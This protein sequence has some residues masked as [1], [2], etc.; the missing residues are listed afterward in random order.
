[1]KQLALFGISVL[2][3]STSLRADTAMVF[4][5][6][7]Y[8]P[9]VNEPALEWLEFHNQLAVD[10]DVSGW[11]V[12]GGISYTFP[13]GS[14]IR[15]RGYLV[16][17]VN[18]GA[19]ASATGL[20]N[21][22]GPFAGRLDNS[23]DT[24]ELRNNSGRLMDRLSYEADGNWPVGP[25]GAGVSLAKRDRNTASD[26]AANWTVSAEQ[27]GTPGVDNFPLIG[28]ALPDIPLVTFE[29]EWKYN[30]SGQDLGTAW[31]GTNYDDS[32]WS[33]GRAWFY[34]GSIGIS[35]R[36]PITTVYNTGIGTDGVALAP[37]TRDPHYVLTVAAQGTVP[38]N[39]LVTENHSAWLANDNSSR[40]VSVVTPGTANINGGA[41]FYSTTFDINGFNPGTAQLDINMAI[42]NL[43]TNVFLNGNP[44]AI[45]FVGF[46]ALSPTFTISSG[47]VD[48]L[49]TLEFRTVNEGVGPGAFRAEVRGSGLVTSTNTSL[50]AIAKYYLRKSFTYSGDGNVAL[51]LNSLIDD[52]AI[53]YLN[54]TEI[55]R[56]NMA[57]PTNVIQPAFSGQIDVPASSLA[58]GNNVLAV[59]L[60]QAP[61]DTSDILFD[62]ELVA[63]PSTT[64]RQTITFNE[65]SAGGADFWVEL[66]NGTGREV[67][68]E[69]L[70]LVRDGVSDNVYFFGEGTL[71]VDGFLVLS[72]ATLDFSVVSGDKLFLFEGDQLLDGIAIRNRARARFPNSNGHWFNP[73]TLTPGASNN[74]VFRS[75]I[76]INEIMYNHQPLPPTNNAVGRSSDE[77][78]IELYNRSSS[79]IDLTDWE[80]TG[81]I[82][83]RFTPGKTIPAH[84]YLVV[85]DDVAAL[86]AIYPAADIVG[87]YG[88]RLG[89]NGERVVLRDPS[90]NPADEVRYFEGGRWPDHTGGGGSSLELRNPDADNSNA[91]A[92]AASDESS[93]STWQT[94]NYAMT[95]AIPAASGQPT[96][97]NDF[98]M[99]LQSAGECLIDDLTVVE[100]NTGLA[101]IDNGDFENG[102]TGWRVLGTHNRSSVIV[103]PENPGNH[104]MRVV[105]TGPQE[106]MH[107]HIERTYLAGRS[108]QNNNGYRITFRAR[109]LAGNNLLNTR[110]YFNRVGRTAAL[111]TPQLNGTP[112]AQNSQYAANVGPTFTDFRHQPVIP[113]PSTPVRVS[114]KAADANG[115]TVARLW[116]SVNDT[117]WNNVVMDRNGSE[118]SGTI[119]GQSSGTIQFYVNATDSLGATTMFPA[120]GPDGGALYQVADGR[121]NL[122]L[123]HNV[124]II[125]TASNINYMHGVAQGSNQTNVMSNDL[126]PCTVIYDE[127]RAYYD[128]GV[129]LRGSQRGRY[130][131]VRT[132]FHLTFQPDDPFLGLHPVM[133]VDRSGAGDAAANR[134]ED[135]ILK[136]MLNRAG[137]LPGTYSQIAH[138]IAPRTA[139]SGAAQWFPRHEDNFIETA[140]ENG[141]DGTM[142]E[143]ELIY[144]PTT[145]NSIGYKLPQPDGV[146]G[147]DMTDMGNDKEFYR[148]NFMMKSHRNT[149]DYSRFIAICKAL[150]LTGT[151]LDTATRQ[152]MDIDQWMRAY[153][154][155]SLCSVGDMYTFGNNHNFFMYQRAGDGKF[156]YFPWDMDFT[157]TRGSSGALV[158]DQNLGKLVNLPGNLRCMYAH[159]LDIINTTFNTA[160]MGYWI[161]H[162]DNFA[163]GQNYSGH[164]TTLGARVTFVQSQIATAGGNSPFVVTGTNDITTST[165]LMTFTGTAPVTMKTIMI[166]GKEYP[167]TWTSVFN[168]RIVVPITE[169]SNRLDFVGYDIKGNPQTNLTRTVTVRYTGPLPNLDRA[170]VF[171]EIMY[172][173]QTPDTAF[174]ELYNRSGAALDISDWR[175]NGL[176]Y[177]FPKGSIITNG[178]YLL[179]VNQLSAYAAAFGVNATV[180]FDEFNASLQNDGETLTLLRP[181]ITAGQE[182]VV[183]RVKYEDV[184]P[185]PAAADGQ[186]A[187]LQLIDANENNARVGNWADPTGWRYVTYTGTIQG[188]ATPS[189]RG[190][191]FFM[192]LNSAGDV[193]IDDMKLVIGTVPEAG[194]NLLVNGDFEDAL[195]P[196]NWNISGNH[197]STVR[198]STVSHS[199]S[200]SLRILST[201]AGSIVGTG[202][203]NLRQFIP[204]NTT[205]AVC[206]LSFW[207]LPGASGNTMTIRTAPGSAFNTSVSIQPILAT[208]GVANTV[209][210]DLATFPE[211]Y[212]NE[213]QP[214]NIAGPLDNQGERE[215]WIEIYNAGSSTLGLDGYYL[216]DNY[217]STTQWPF[218]PGSSIGA[219]EFKVV[220]VDGEPGESTATEWHAN[221]RA[222]AG[223]G[224]ISLA[225]AALVHDYL[226]YTNVRP[227]WSYGAYPDGQLFTR[228]AFF[229]ATP[230]GT[231]DN[232]P[233]P[234]SVFINEWMA[235]NTHTLLNTNNNNRFDD[236]F[237]LYNPTVFPADLTGYRLTDNLTDPSPFI[238]PPGYVV[239]PQGFLLVWADN[240]PGL[241]NTNDAALHV[242]FR[243]ERG[244]ESIALVAPGGAIIDS[245]TFEPQFEDVSQGRHQDGFGNIYF[246]ASPTPK[247]PNTS[248]IN[249]YPV[250]NAISDQTALV[251]QP[252][253]Y[254][255]AASDPDGHALSYSLDIAPAGAAI[256]GSGDLSWLPSATGT[257]LVTVRVTDNGTIPLSRSV[258][259]N[260][261]VTTGIRIGT[262]TRTSPTELSISLAATAGK[263]YRAEY[264][265]NLEDSGWTPVLPS[266]VAS[267]PTVTIAIPI[268]PEPHRFFRITQVD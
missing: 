267:G 22:F 212:L 53:F 81:G 230:G 84:G 170:V 7:M 143:M 54:G 160:Y 92:W 48:G 19:L 134:Q 240:E 221:F 13:N 161:D 215:P 106:H 76:V 17:A 168:W 96:Q 89:G 122:P 220:F 123:T 117:A 244:G 68:L 56:F 173:P 256:N 85:A 137:G 73:T 51:R 245:V 208:P 139:H 136:H 180:P 163:P 255:V 204:G 148:Y 176:D 88:G 77:E 72:N 43:C 198:S 25:D 74:V 105:A 200:S 172:N 175:I 95:G 18:P 128:I 14:I 248:W 165:Q 199:G 233:P 152:V 194:A 10:L 55:H 236:W 125:L 195:A 69:N 132:G 218:P 26:P 171:N 209:A 223:H 196:A 86:R 177:T 138:V 188:N 78:W 150:S 52:G 93:K 263:T 101:M 44:T 98:I 11:S 1:M 59:E 71:P 147:T 203:N 103:D 108:V 31:R 156:L 99:G 183:A 111:P 27:G 260:I 213:V 237:E 121:A 184:L 189:L 67:N 120:R 190:T 251:N 253:A 252:F 266:T 91:E 268:G 104:V 58:T 262:I 265:D 174:V 141:G 166:N 201:G 130:S 9:T 41:Y 37:G 191:N 238:I 90:G 206:T 157:F 60:H 118:F 62:A 226:N 153:A 113:S 63:S 38:T 247:A 36:R 224:S 127:N 16:L 259:F 219:G 133:L 102:L 146:V 124:R 4:N 231:N 167:I 235:D 46:A 181:G 216:S 197:S 207:L 49:N 110:L 205:N 135:I 5:E 61:G 187:S 39:A 222:Q 192:L 232:T 155:V 97:W 214:E 243:L 162:Y 70:R 225:T 239:P 126:L 94:F 114:V 193:H 164:L 112:G 107:N 116:W 227:N 32:A 80:L 131:D 42:D 241:N 30:A 151:A 178:Q 229:H 3:A 79:P 258:S 2:L 65:H 12:A 250:L 257:N 144:Y 20:P 169:A 83:Y 29:S 211:L 261:I 82:D 66:A 142:F 8:H 57:G 35:Q 21:I 217:G 145:A 64:E 159:M 87:N 109:W 45:S 34:N 129:H 246:L 23:G 6:V 40:W 210:R 47:L 249:R 50:P 264:K 140:F 185:W 119:P 75:E 149:D 28:V 24:L 182:I 228:Q 254:H 154:M 33:S 186:G 100:T 115:V 179:L 158:G 234:I 15:G 242:N 202:G